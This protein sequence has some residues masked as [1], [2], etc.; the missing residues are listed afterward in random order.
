MSKIR[1]LAVPSDSHGVGKFR[2]LDPFT[3]IGDNHSDEVHVDIVFDVP[4]SDDYFSNYDIVVFHSFIH[5][6]NHEENLKRIGWLK[7]NGIKVVMDTDDFW[8]VD[9]RHPNY[10]TFKKNDLAKKRVELLRSVD[11]VTTTTSIYRDTIKKSLNIKNVEIFPNA[12]NE[13]ESQFKPNPIKSEKVRF[14]WLG[15]SSH[16]HDLELLRGGISQTQN[17]FKDKVQFVLCG[18]DTRGN[19]REIN[20]LT[21][22]VRERPIRPEETVWAKYEEIFTNRYNSVTEDYASFLK[23][24]QNTSYPNDLDQPYVRRWTMDIN[25]YATNYNYFDVSLAP[26]VSTEFNHNKSQLKVIEAG[27]HKKA[28]IASAENPYLIDLV[29]G[30]ENGNFTENGNSLLVQSS[31]NHKQWNQHMKRLIENPNMITDLG[32]RL[33]E[34]VEDKYSLSTVSKNRV[35]FFKSIINK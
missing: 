16:Y 1:I 19:M 34:T 28:I 5:K 23:T 32:N 26:I 33:Y 21:G 20:K 17:Q 14:G 35:E 8:R 31:K 12:V 25:K 9:Q 29:S 22:Q 4:N 30:Y 27:F 2:I 13:K 11:Y 10:E 6:T 3:Y 15:G 24:Y 18:F 7:E